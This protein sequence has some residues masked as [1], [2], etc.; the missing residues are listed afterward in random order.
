MTKEKQFAE[1]TCFREL[2]ITFC[3]TPFIKRSKYVNK[4]DS[5]FYRG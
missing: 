2:Q 5:E 3:N 1:T 4:M